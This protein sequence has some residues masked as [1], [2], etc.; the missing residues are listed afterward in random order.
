MG[1]LRFW[2]VAFTVLVLCRGTA[3]ASAEAAIAALRDGLTKARAIAESDEPRAARV[4]RLHTV[5]RELVDTRAM[6]ELAIGDVLATQPPAKVEEF[7]DLFSELLVRSYLQKLLFFREPRFEIR[8]HRTTATGIVI[9]TAM[10]TAKDE[11]SVDY[12]MRQGPRGWSATDV[13]IEG[14][15]LRDS[16]RQQFRTLLDQRSFDELLELMRGKVGGL[17]AKQ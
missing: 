12:E 10:L 3:H 4:A 16:Y 1:R 13:V 11:Y 6:G 2:P 9:S 7:H 17:R 5:A 14:L 15:S 8:H